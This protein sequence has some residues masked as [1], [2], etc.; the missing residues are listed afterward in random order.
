MFST[1]PGSLPD[2]DPS[3]SA[4]A[5]AVKIPSAD[6]LCP[7]TSVS[8]LFLIGAGHSKCTTL[9]GLDSQSL[10]AELTRQQLDSSQADRRPILSP[11]SH[12]AHNSIRMND[13]WGSGDG[14]S[15][16]FATI[17]PSPIHHPPVTSPDLLSQHVFPSL[18]DS[19]PPPISPILLVSPPSISYSPVVLDSLLKEKMNYRCTYDPALDTSVVKKSS[20]PLWVSSSLFFKTLLIYRL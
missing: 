19:P 8:D 10:Q 18:P 16:S 14:K 1:R 15:A 7:T 6:K 9:T 11:S 20:G 13:S 4:S 3:A 5:V 2:F 12:L 17:R